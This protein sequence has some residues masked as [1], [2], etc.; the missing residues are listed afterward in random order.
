MIFLGEET[1]WVEEETAGVNVTNQAKIFWKNSGR[2]YVV[3]CAPE[4]RVCHVN[5]N[6]QSFIHAVFFLQEIHAKIYCS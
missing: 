2:I 1:A 5:M 4:T 6:S 3:Q